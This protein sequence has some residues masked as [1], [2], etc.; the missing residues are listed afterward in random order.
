MSEVARWL[1]GLG[2]PEYGQV[3]ADNMVDFE[4]LVDL[5]DDDLKDLGVP[6]GHRK[7]L[8]RGIAA[9]KAG[10]TEQVAEEKAPAKPRSAESGE[11]ER[12][13]LTVMFVD[14]VGSTQLSGELDPE[15][16]R[17]VMR[18]YQDAVAG[19]VTRYSGHVAKYLGD[20]VLAYFGWPQAYEDQ[21]E[22]A[23]KAGL[24]AVTA[25]GG[26]TLANG[27]SL[28]A[29]VG[30]AT[31]RVVI[32][33]LVGETGRDADAVSGETPNLAARL[34]QLAKPGQVVVDNATRRV[35]GGRTSETR[36]AAGHDAGMTTFVGRRNEINLLADRWQQA[37]GGEGQVVLLSGEAGIGKSRITQALRDLAA[38][39]EP[40]RLR[41]QCAPYYTDSVLYPVIHQFEYAARI[42]PEDVPEVK[43]EKVEALLAQS[44]DM[45]TEIT[46]LVAALLSI[47]T[48]DRYP[49]LDLSAQAQMAETLKGIVDQY[50]GLAKRKPV[51]M[52]VEDVHWADPTTLEMLERLIDQV[53]GARILMVITF[54]PEFVP[55]WRGHTHI[56]SLALNR[57]GRG[58]CEKIV[59]AVAGGKLL[60]AAVQDQIIA[61]TDGVALF[62]EE[63]TKMVIESSLVQDMGDRYDLVQPLSALAIPT[64]L[65]DSLMA[66]LDRL[67]PVKEIAQT[68]AAIGRE[69]S[70]GLL[71]A[72][73]PLNN[74]DLN[75]ALAQLVDAELIFRRGTPP[76]ATYI[77]KHA[78]VRD[79]A[80]ESLLRSRRYVLHRDIATSLEK[81]FPEIAELEPEIL[82][83]HY[84]EA[85][86]IEAAAG[87]WCH[88]G[89][90]AAE[91]WANSIAIDHLTRGLEIVATL[92]PSLERDRLELDL[93]LAYSPVIMAVEGYGS[94]TAEQSFERIRELSETLD[95]HDSRFTAMCGLW[96]MNLLR[97]SVAVSKRYSDE[98]W[99]ATIDSNNLDHLVQ[100]RHS[101]WS[102]DLYAGDPVSCLEHATAGYS[103][104]DR[105]KHRSHKFLYGT[106]DP[107]VCGLNH[108][109]L[110]NV[111]L[112][113]ADEASRYVEEAVELAKDLAHPTTMVMAY[114]FATMSH[115]FRGDAEAAGRYA[116]EGIALCDEFR[117]PG[118]GAGIE[119]TLG[120]A[121]FKQGAGAESIA[122]LIAGMNRWRSEGNMVYWPW[123]LTLRAEAEMYLGN[124]DEA[125]AIVSDGLS[126]SARTGEHWVDADL[127]RLRGEI[128]LAQSAD[129]KVTAEAVFHQALEMA[130][131]HRSVLLELRATRSLCRLWADQGKHSEAKKM[132]QPIFGKFTEGFS[133]PDLL[134]AKALLDAL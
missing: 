44:T 53:Q 114:M 57:L 132:L 10:P 72:V 85:G 106:H 8:L 50:I 90:R 103:M 46:P 126:L 117:I 124:H 81:Y 31:G 24:D 66:R 89:R 33:D 113:H 91:R 102:S 51:L 76:D 104:Y 49:P 115:H 99:S 26:V 97:G 4:V 96:Q 28:A 71:A 65:Q 60:P 17:D 37:K 133:T 56:T 119:A 27:A 116:T 80:Y 84:T 23:L 123:F 48:G 130:R 118:W 129:E 88:A 61:K 134:E 11:A 5:T 83:H 36:F 87:Y 43:L 78:L 18:R 41:Q 7:K 64:T 70:H 86:Q 75:A 55:A 47:P 25:V 77:F 20:G 19:A 14:L 30:V 67:A 107:G 100:A 22:R 2:L 73:S 109:G 82:A 98:L 108:K 121:Q 32:G 105:E 42:A 95:D 6:L 1:T 101:C 21:T 58:Q 59:S 62:V 40:M 68:G 34:E 12:R 122:Q 120:W 45:V 110:T 35:V 52:I 74:V 93:R 3:F 13:Q 125:L 111:I 127:L 54:R 79:A 92:V 63:L 131:G 94:T 29:R 39:D 112:G 69:F 128:L 9:L 16:L 15:D 38:E